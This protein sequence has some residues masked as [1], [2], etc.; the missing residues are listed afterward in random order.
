M[1]AYRCLSSSFAH[2][3]GLARNHQYATKVGDEFVMKMFPAAYPELPEE[4]LEKVAKG[5][6]EVED[7]VVVVTVGEE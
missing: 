3:P 7:D 4:A 5:E 1:T 6:Y 2:A